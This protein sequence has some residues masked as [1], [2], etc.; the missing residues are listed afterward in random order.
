M[1]RPVDVHY[2][3]AADIQH[4]R[5][6]VLTAAYATHPERFVRHPPVPLALPETAWI[7]QPVPKEEVPLPTNST[8]SISN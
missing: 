8:I 6:R 2:G 7:N 4:H 1:H 5:G 3:H